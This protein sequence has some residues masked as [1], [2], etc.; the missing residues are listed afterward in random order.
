M[1]L[2]SLQ[3]CTAG[4]GKLPMNCPEVLT[5]VPGDETVTLHQGERTRERR[6]VHRQDIDQIIRSGARILLE[7]RQE[8]EVRDREVCRRQ[9]GVVLLGDDPSRPSQGRTIAL[10]TYGH[11]ITVCM[12]MHLV[13]QP[14]TAVVRCNRVEIILIGAH[15]GRT[16][17]PR[18]R[19]ENRAAHSSCC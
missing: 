13:K 16:D 18:A 7:R 6:L 12:Y 15:R 3:S 14:Q 19:S 10:K 5:L 1:R 17:R 9:C 11:A 4:I 2:G 8:R